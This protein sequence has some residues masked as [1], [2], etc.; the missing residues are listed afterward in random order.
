MR[1]L[2]RG[3]HNLDIFVHGFFEEFVVPHKGKDP[4][5]PASTTPPTGAFVTG[6]TLV[7]V[8]HGDNISL[9]QGIV[10][11]IP[12]MLQG[13]TDSMPDE[14]LI[15]ARQIGVKGEKGRRCQNIHLQGGG[16][17]KDVRPYRR[18]T[19]LRDGDAMESRVEI[20]RVKVTVPL[21]CTPIK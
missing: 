14:T 20:W 15:R 9:F 8:M 5:H 21:A 18:I 13:R 10:N 11:D 19:A 2:E 1:R 12:E 17:G 7:S 4:F 6:S 16:R 3:R